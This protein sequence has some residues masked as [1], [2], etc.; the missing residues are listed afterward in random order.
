MTKIDFSKIKVT[1][2]EGNEVPMDVRFLFG[3][4]LY[5]QG[6]NVEECELGREIFKQSPDKPLELTDSQASIVKAYAE[7]L[8]YVT[9]QAILKAFSR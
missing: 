5:M 9:R 2:I 8:P 7:R 3:N 1:D 4:M 6:V